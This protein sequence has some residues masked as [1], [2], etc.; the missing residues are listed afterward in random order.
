MKK[1]IAA[2]ALAVASVAYADLIVLP[3]SLTP[4]QDTGIFGLQTC[5]PGPAGCGESGNLTTTFNIDTTDGSVGLAF[6]GISQPPDGLFSFIVD[7]FDPLNVLIASGAGPAGLIIAPFNVFIGGPYTID[8]DWTYTPGGST[9]QSASWGGV[10]A[11]SAAQVPEPN[12]LGLLG[13][14]LAGMGFVTLRRK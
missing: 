8:V 6:I 4:G 1:L 5:P 3:G 12:T 7:V 11:T 2:L 9:T 14:A 10:A 13:L